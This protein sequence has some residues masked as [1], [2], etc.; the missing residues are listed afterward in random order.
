MD[1]R[2]RGDDG[3]ISLKKHTCKNGSNVAEYMA[4]RRKITAESNGTIVFGINSQNL[5]PDFCI[6][7]PPFFA[8]S[9]RR[10][11]VGGAVVGYDRCVCILF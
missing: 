10:F 3:V 9:K 1:P 11:A 4:Y 2:L 7:Y 6:F 5:I 8:E